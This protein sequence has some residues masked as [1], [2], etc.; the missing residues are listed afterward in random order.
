MPGEIVHPVEREPDEL[1]AMC[2]CLREGGARK[3]FSPHLTRAAAPYGVQGLNEAVAR[4]D[5]AR[6]Q[7]GSVAEGV[8]ALRM[9]PTAALATPSGR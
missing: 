2:S 5:Y 8:G 6:S 3:L 9:P 4:A 7:F 1:T